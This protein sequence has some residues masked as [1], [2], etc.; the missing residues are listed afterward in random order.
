MLAQGNPLLLA[1]F[2]EREISTR[3]AGSALG[4]IWA[5]L[6]PLLLLAIY[7]F[8]FGQLFQQRLGDLGTESYTLFVAI[9]LWPWMMFS[10]ALLRAMQSIQSNA[11]LVK[12]V[13]FPHMLLVLAAIN[14]VFLVHLA[15]YV[16]VLVVLAL[17]GTPVR[18]AGI[19]V[20]LI[21]IATLYFLA[22]AVGAILAALQTLLRDVEQA[23]TPAIM[24]LHYLTPVLYPIT[25]IPPAYRHWLSWNPLA[26][27]MQR[28]RDGLLLGG[29][30]QMGDLW[31]L[32][33]GMVLALLGVAFFMRLSPY[34]EDFL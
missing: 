12:K 2:T 19:P 16:A 8:I 20:A 11:A 29:S 32:L 7:S 27:I 26:Y 1:R 13:A 31:M 17:T 9:A 18:L 24:M 14:S 22:I 5:L 6:G 33:A 23:V 10:D 28:L 4:L 30:V 34:F 15:G 21:A 25:L 3:F